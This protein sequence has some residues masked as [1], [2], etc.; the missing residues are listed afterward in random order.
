MNKYS[1]I[2]YDLESTKDL[3]EKYLLVVSYEFKQFSDFFIYFS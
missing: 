3:N 2:Y 1:N